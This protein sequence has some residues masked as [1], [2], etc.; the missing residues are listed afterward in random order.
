[1]NIEICN[2]YQYAIA[3]PTSMG[4]RITPED[5]MAAGDLTLDPGNYAVRKNGVPG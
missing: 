1:M 4:V 3:C 5:R 2:H